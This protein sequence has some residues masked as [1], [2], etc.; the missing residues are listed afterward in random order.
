MESDEEGFCG[1]ERGCRFKSGRGCLIL[2]LDIR[3]FAVA[4]NEVTIRKACVSRDDRGNFP[5]KPSLPSCMV[6]PSRAG[7]EAAYVKSWPKVSF[8]CSGQYAFAARGTGLMPVG[9]ERKPF[10]T[11]KVEVGRSM[12]FFTSEVSE[13]LHSS[14]Q[15][16]V[17]HCPISSP[18]RT[19]TA[20]CAFSVL[21]CFKNFLVRVSAG[22]ACF[23]VVDLLLE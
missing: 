10:S 14:F 18:R 12:T 20:S 19:R 13:L 8:I 4:V 21:F 9:S 7:C 11:L 1:S 17:M 5:G 2:V 16:G 3:S 6:T 22:A 15:L 23:I